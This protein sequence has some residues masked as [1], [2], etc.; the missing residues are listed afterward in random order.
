ML[1]TRQIAIYLSNRGIGRFVE[2][3]TGGNIFINAMPAQPNE[4]I[5]IFATGGPTIDPRNE[6]ASRAIQVL[7]RTAANDPRPGETTAQSVIDVLKGFNTGYLAAGG[8]YVVD[9]EASQDGPN[10]IGQDEN[11]RYEFSQN[12]IVQIR[13]ESTVAA[14][15]PSD[16]VDGSG[17][18]DDGLTTPSE[19]S[20][21]V[22]AYKPIN[23][24]AE[25]VGDREIRIRWELTGATPGDLSSFYVFVNDTMIAAM[26]PDDREF[27]TVVPDN[28][29]I[30]IYVAAI[31]DEPYS[32]HYSEMITL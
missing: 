30:R 5:A 3:G 19:P 12:F 28:Q 11:G 8:N 25:R 18:E 23:L 13:K 6:Y 4:A 21:Q 2:G 7:I 10:N 16:P 31:V 22:S 14:P 9:V 20:V 15:A 17:T 1:L 26:G 24:S 29:V 27:V 32:E